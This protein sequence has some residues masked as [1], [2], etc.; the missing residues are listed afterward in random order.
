MV[1]RHIPL[2][3]WQVRIALTDP[4]ANDEFGWGCKNIFSFNISDDPTVDFTYTAEQ[5]KRMP[6]SGKKESC[7]GNPRKFKIISNQNFSKKTTEKLQLSL[8]HLTESERKLLL[9]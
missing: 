6:C 3:C 7:W 9:F 2:Q 5:N 4:E 8:L 1:Q